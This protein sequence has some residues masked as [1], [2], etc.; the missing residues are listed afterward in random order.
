[1]RKKP[2]PIG[3]EQFQDLEFT[4]TCGCRACDGLGRVDTG[5]DEVDCAVCDGTGRET[6]LMS[7]EELAKLLTGQ[8]G[9]NKNPI[10]RLKVIQRREQQKQKARGAQII[11]FPTQWPEP[12][13]AMPSCLLRSALFGIV[14]KGRRQ[15]VQRQAIAAWPGATIRYTGFQLDQADLDVWLALLHVARQYDLGEEIEI[16][17]HSLLKMLGRST[18]KTDHE[19]LKG[20]IARLTGGTVEITLGDKTYGG[21]LIQAFERDESTGHHRL[22]LNPKLAVLFKDS[23]FTRIN[24]EIR[25]GLQRDLAKWLLGYIHSHKATRKAPHRIGLTKLQALCGSETSE[26]KQFRRQV[27]AAMGELEQ[28]GV[29]VAWKLTEGD[30]LELVRPRKRSLID[31]G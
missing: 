2:D 16:T 26:L 14:R 23:N 28:A 30:A 4:A 10:H 27:K 22:Q 19:W 31:A 29:V 8:A 1:M 11:P 3:L 12:E 9:I 5:L 7:L 20:V 25:A 15:A 17:A 13:R 24:W 21:S 6:V 18:G